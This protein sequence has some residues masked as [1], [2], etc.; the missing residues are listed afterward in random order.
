MTF[1]FNGWQR[2]GIVLSICWALLVAGL[3]ATDWFNT[4]W[5][6]GVFIEVVETV[7]VER[8]PDVISSNGSR[9]NPDDFFGPRMRQV[10]WF[11]IKTFV[12]A[13]L[14]PITVSW[15]LASAGAIAYRWVRA[16]FD[17]SK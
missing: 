11:D 7:P 8:S 14:L 16:G 10:T 17:R 12:F 15:L 4:R 13:M 2:L 1:A 6:T 9:Y 5:S 3:G